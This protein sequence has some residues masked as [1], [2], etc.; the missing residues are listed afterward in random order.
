MTVAMITASTMLLACRAIPAA[1]AIITTIRILFTTIICFMVAEGQ[2]C[3]CTRSREMQEAAEVAK[4]S[5]QD[6]DAAAKPM[7]SRARSAGDTLSLI[8]R[9]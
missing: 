9:R 2:R 8:S 3:R 5:V 1:M 6:M 4:V 7:E